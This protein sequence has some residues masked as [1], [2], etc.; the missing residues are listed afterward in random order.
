[1]QIFLILFSIL[2]IL[3]GITLLVF[4]LAVPNWYKK[5][6]KSIINN[7]IPEDLLA[8][9]ITIGAISLIFGLIIVIISLELYPKR[10]S[11]RKT[12]KSKGVKD[13]YLKRKIKKGADGGKYYLSRKCDTDSGGKLVC[14]MKK[15]Y[16]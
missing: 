8:F 15:N 9:T 5:T 6:W 2:L 12:K 7:D 11:K 13:I 4:A 14:K 10:K 16:I 1:M 3:F